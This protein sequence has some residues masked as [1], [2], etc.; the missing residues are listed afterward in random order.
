[1]S[2]QEILRIAEERAALLFEDKFEKETVSSLKTRYSKILS[3]GT[4]DTSEMK[5]CK[6]WNALFRYYIFEK[7]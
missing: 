7:K 3:Y 1:M 4:S 6:A 5:A 2:K